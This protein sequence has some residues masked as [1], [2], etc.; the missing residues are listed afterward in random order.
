MTVY[1]ESNFVLEIA[2][3]QEQ[4]DAAQAI[5]E[6]AERREIA[7]ALPAFSLSEPF[8]TVSHRSRRLQQLRK[9]LADE[10]RERARSGPH[11]KDVQALEPTSSFLA[12][13][14]TRE[15]ERLIL[16]VGRLYASAIVIPM[17]ASV[18][19]EAMIVTS[20]WGLTP[21]D[22][23]INSAVLEHI[24]TSRLPGPR[25]FIN[26]NWRDFMGT[27][28]QTELVALNCEFHRT[29]VDAE[30]TLMRTFTD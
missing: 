12:S 9:Q 23:M 27:R 18:Y 19:A 4:S 15:L 14:E 30:S 29:F 25:V 6:R 2:L 5:L 17:D 28:I 1:V 21:Q 22:A 10:L 20:Q 24:R 16:T 3:G 7:L 11:Q 26:K 13:I 8:S